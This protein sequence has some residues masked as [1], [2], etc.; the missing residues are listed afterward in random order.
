MRKILAGVAG[1]LLLA[2]PATAWA[3]PAELGTLAGM[4]AREAEAH[5]IWSMRAGLNVAALQCSF[6]KSYRMVENYNAFLRQHADELASAVKTLAGYFARTA[7]ARNGPRANDRYNTKLYQ[8]YSTFEAQ[9]AFCDRA[10]MIVRAALGVPKG[11]LG[12]FVRA[13]LP[14]LRQALTASYRDEP[15]AQTSLSLVKVPDLSSGC[16]VRGNPPLLRC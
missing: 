1:W 3:T 5:A 2:A 16:S 4:T 10:A 8:G 9:Y 15:L 11:K 7:G 12:G 6:S 14:A 13:E